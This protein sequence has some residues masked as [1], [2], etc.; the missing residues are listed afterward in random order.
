MSGNGQ[1]EFE[2]VAKPQERTRTRSTIAFPY[3]D[4]ET[5]IDVANAVHDN[6]GRG[7][8]D[9]DQ[10]AAWRDQSPKSST[11]RVQVYASRTFGILESESGKHKLTELGL[12]L[13]DPSRERSARIKAFLTVP[14]F[15]AMFDIYKSG[16]LPPAATIE[17]EMVKLGVSEKQKDRARVVFEKSAEQAG[18]FAA[19]RNRLVMPGVTSA[20]GDGE[21]LPPGENGQKEDD[22]EKNK[23]TGG[24]GPP[25][26][27]LH[28]FIQGLL[29]TLPKPESKWEAVD[30]V[31]W[32][33]TAA[34]IFDLIYEGNGSVEVR[35][36]AQPR[37]AKSD[38]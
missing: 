29:A 14:L 37:S 8:C 5:A 30:R 4:L 9:D 7:E 38:E 3:A 16:V 2:D 6:V 28:P 20:G 34:S 1:A 36:V 10:L 21:K 33:Q 23:G 18:F 19:G 22:K 31:K 25:S 24:G 32:L 12:E 15:K 13:V 35:T 11:F 17:R 27:T 26:G